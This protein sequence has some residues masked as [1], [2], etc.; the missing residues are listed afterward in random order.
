MKKIQGIYLLKQNDTVV[1]VGK[2]KEVIKRIRYHN[3]SEKEFNKIDIYSFTNLADMDIAEVKLIQTYRAIYNKDCNRG[4][5]STLL[6]YIELPEP[7]SY[8]VKEFYAEFGT[9]RQELAKADIQ[10]VEGAITSSAHMVGLC[11]LWAAETIRNLPSRTESETNMLVTVYMHIVIRQFTARNHF[12]LI[13]A[14]TFPVASTTR[15]RTIK[16]LKDLGFINYQR[17]MVK[18]NHAL[19]RY[20][21]LEPANQIQNFTLI[22]RD[23]TA[24]EQ[25]ADTYKGIDGKS[26]EVYITTRLGDSPTM[27]FINY[28][29]ANN[30]NHETEL[31]EWKLK[32]KDNK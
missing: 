8:T 21:V 30:I 22:G 20:T 4:E 23:D 28:C 13:K 6:Q 14:D 7:V 27:E 9:Y 18:G 17:T 15:K 3:S 24:K 16:K 32:Q 10:E 31:I 2:S 12:A 25:A 19:T 26:Y 1:Y 11:Y 5:H 29:K